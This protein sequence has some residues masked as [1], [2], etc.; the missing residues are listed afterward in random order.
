[1]V[2]NGCDGGSH[3]DFCLG[4][5]VNHLLRLLE[6]IS[7]SYRLFSILDNCKRFANE[8][9]VKLG[10]TQ[11]IL[12]GR[13]FGIMEPLSILAATGTT[14]SI[15]TNV[16]NILSTIMSQMSGVDG[17]MQQLHREV[18]DFKLLLIRMKGTFEDPRMKS[19]ALEAQTGFIGRYWTDVRNFIERC[20]GPLRE[21]EL[22]RHQVV[23]RGESAWG[24]PIRAVT[25]NLSASDIAYYRDE[26]KD[27]R[28]NMQLSLQMI[29]V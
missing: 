20:Q 19:A 7:L 4:G 1:M 11:S 28:A 13:A 2:W 22:L 29:V 3:V 17:S 24:R 8:K 14:I 9:Q 15:A 5:L 21:L 18:Q 6:T 25:L 16:V 27:F 12:A 26:I 23:G 10:N